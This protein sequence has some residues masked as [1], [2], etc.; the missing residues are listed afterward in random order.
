MFDVAVIVPAWHKSDSIGAAVESAIALLEGIAKTF[1]II[2]V[3]DGP[4]HETYSSAL[5]I[6]DER[7]RVFQLE[8]NSG[9]GNAL[10][11][12]IEKSNSDFVAFIDADSDIDVS[13]LGFALIKIEQN[14]D[15]NLCCVYGSKVHS[16]SN[17]TYPVARRLMSRMHRFL[18]KKLFDLSVEDSQTGLKLYR[19][20]ALKSVLVDSRQ[21]GFL[22]DLEIFVLLSRR[23][24]SFLAI[25][26]AIDFKFSST[27]N[28]VEIWRII[29]DT[30]RLRREIN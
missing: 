5:T 21:N 1:E 19:S 4:D 12:G 13:A 24:F 30:V 28:I 15:P 20:D 10:R 14:D 9:K 3:V 7:V 27:V 22:F 16:E 8:Q 29:R 6:R 17:V 25:P 18:V 2:V 11:R 23:G 26:V